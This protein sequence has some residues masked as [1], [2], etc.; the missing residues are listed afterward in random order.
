MVE[1]GK[2]P[3]GTEIEGGLASLQEA[4]GGDSLRI[5]ADCGGGIGSVGVIHNDVLP[6]QIVSC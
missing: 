4:V 6:F 3:Y 1:P 2:S 5:G